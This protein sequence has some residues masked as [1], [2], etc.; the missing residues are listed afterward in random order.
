VLAEA[1]R[2]LAAAR[3]TND[4]VKLAGALGEVAAAAVAWR[5]VL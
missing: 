4:P 1:L 3:T 5:D 2:G